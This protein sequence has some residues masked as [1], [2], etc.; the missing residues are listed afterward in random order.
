MK[1]R[2][3]EESFDENTMR[4]LSC[5]IENFIDFIIRKVMSKN[6]RIKYEGM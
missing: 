2:K 3:E 1:R 5:R 4:I 6:K